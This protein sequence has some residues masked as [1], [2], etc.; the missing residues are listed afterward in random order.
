VAHHIHVPAQI[1][2]AEKYHVPC[3][4]LIRNPLDTITST[5]VVDEQQSCQL[6]LLSYI[7]F[8]KRILPIRHRIIIAFF[9]E[10]ISDFGSII[11]KTNICYNT[12]FN[13]GVITPHIK[14]LIYNKLK[15]INAQD[16]TQIPSNIAIPTEEKEKRKHT[17]KKQ[18]QQHP[19]LQKA[20]NVYHAFEE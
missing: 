9:N 1:L 5:I 11:E 8:Y 17:I 18:V 12:R 14:N 20:E 19:L 2:L 7:A 16:A 6:A 3:I 4:V 10:V 15:K 13:Y